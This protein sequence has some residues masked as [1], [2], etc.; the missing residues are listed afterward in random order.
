M[1]EAEVGE[2]TTSQ[3]MSVLLLE[4]TNASVDAW[5]ASIQ[6]LHQHEYIYCGLTI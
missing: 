6:L 2:A 3:S 4:A 5:P 1:P